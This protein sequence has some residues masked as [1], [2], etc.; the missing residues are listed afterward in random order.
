MFLEACGALIVYTQAHLDPGIDVDSQ[1]TPYLMSML[2]LTLSANVLTTC[3]LYHTTP[4]RL[5]IPRT[6]LIVYRL[7][8]I[9]CAVEDYQVDRKPGA[10]TRV[11]MMMIESGLFYTMTTLIFF[12]MYVSS[13]N[14]VSVLQD[15][16]SLT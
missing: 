14:A 5:L 3:E 8:E 11:K 10:L 15:T 6:A 12:A 4:L 1:L 9:Q 16:V 13:N 7:H 2:T